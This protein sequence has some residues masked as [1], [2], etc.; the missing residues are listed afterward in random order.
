M[1]SGHVS[2][3]KRPTYDS[4]NPYQLR[5]VLVLALG[6]T[7]VFKIEGWRDCFFSILKKSLFY[8]SDVPG[9]DII[10]WELGRQVRSQ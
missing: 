8:S 1:A 4:D 7:Y 5:T 10:I 3:E 6:T 2:L 9:G